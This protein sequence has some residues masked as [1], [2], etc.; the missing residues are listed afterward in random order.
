MKSI[1]LRTDPI[2]EK[3]APCNQDGFTLLETCIAF[4]LFM[5]VGLGAASLF[6][7]SAGNNTV[8]RDRDLAMA[9]AQ[10]QMELLRNTPFPNLDARV[11]AT[12][13]GD[14]TVE[15][16]GRR[17]R[18]I[19]TVAD[20]VAGNPDRKTITVQVSPLGASGSAPAAQQV[21][22]GVTLV[23]QRSRVVL[24]PNLGL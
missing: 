21:Y 1:R 22:G 12:G 10:G 9:V 8:A 7:F 2:T 18:M 19:T 5:I 4:V 17:Y 20:T 6:V 23:T 13:G 24:G 15:S 16:S 3:S 14:R 11:T